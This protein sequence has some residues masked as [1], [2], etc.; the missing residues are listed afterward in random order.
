MVCSNLNSIN[1]LFSF[2]VK[3]NLCNDNKCIFAGSLYYEKKDLKKIE[4][5]Y[6]KISKLK[7]IL[8]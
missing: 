3:I 5:L 6:H 7:Q 1:F 8:I 4:L 2:Y